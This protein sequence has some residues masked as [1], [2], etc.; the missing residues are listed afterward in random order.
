MSNQQSD[1]N[2]TEWITTAEAAE[3]MRYHV[4]YVRRLVKGGK[5]AGAKRGRDWW[6]DKASVVAYIEEMKQLGSTKHDPWRTGARS[7]EARTGN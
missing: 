5:I 6:V 2:P 1:S 3:M 4:K 7:R